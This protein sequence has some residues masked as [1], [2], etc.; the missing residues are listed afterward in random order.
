MESPF[1]KYNLP[2]RFWPEYDLTEVEVREYK[3]EFHQV[4]GKIFDKCVKQVLVPYLHSLGYKGSRDRFY[5]IGEQ[6]VYTISLFKSE[7]G[8]MTELVVGVHPRGVESVSWDG[9]PLAASRYAATACI[10]HLRLYPILI[11]YSDNRWT[12]G[13]FLNGK[14]E[15]ECLETVE[16]IRSTIAAQ[17]DVFFAK[18]SNFPHPFDQVTLDMLLNAT[19]EFLLPDFYLKHHG[20]TMFARW[21]KIKLLLG[22]VAMAT[23]MVGHILNDPEYECTNVTELSQTINLLNHNLHKDWNRLRPHTKYSFDFSGLQSLFLVEF[24]Y[25]RPDAAARMAIV[26]DPKLVKHIKTLLKSLP[27][28]GNRAMSFVNVKEL[29]VFGCEHGKARALF[30][31]CQD[32]LKTENGLFFENLPTAEESEKVLLTLLQERLS[33]Y[34]CPPGRA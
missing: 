6:L 27:T 4:K 23:Q 2:K 14:T 1:Q 17:A 7:F 34:P 26:D 8:G 29:M 32:R 15:V 30:Q 22:Q 18:F 10:A 28:E 31:F 24:D 9:L 11:N 25:A 13:F 3:D 16:F 5:K 20:T 12:N 33:E 19:G 21:A